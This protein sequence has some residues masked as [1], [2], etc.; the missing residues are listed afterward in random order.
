MKYLEAWSTWSHLELPAM[1]A[2]AVV[3]REGDACVWEIELH[4]GAVVNCL[5]ACWLV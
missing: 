5:A 1:R 2:A 3:E 4:V